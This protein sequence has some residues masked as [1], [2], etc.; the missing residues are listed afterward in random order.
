MK[1]RDHPSLCYRGIRSWPPVWTP[2]D[3]PE[4]KNALRGEIGVLKF[5]RAHPS[6]KQCYIV[7]EHQKTRYIGCVFCSDAKFC[8]QLASM[9]ALRQN[10]TIEQIGDIDLPPV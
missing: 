5:C 2:A 7:M 9:L 8:S 6:D 1:L 3:A 4:D 10:R